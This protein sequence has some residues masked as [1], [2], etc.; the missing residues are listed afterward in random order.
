MQQLIQDC[1]SLVTDENGATALE[2]TV[3]AALLA[4]AVSG[5]VS[6]VASALDCLFI[7]LSCAFDYTLL[8]LRPAAGFLFG[9]ATLLF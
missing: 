3:I 5:R 8:A 4:L 9:M 6:D 7:V 1:R 2:H